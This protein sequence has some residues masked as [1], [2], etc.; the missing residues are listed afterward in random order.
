MPLALK[1]A[2]CLSKPP[3]MSFEEIWPSNK[4]KREEIPVESNDSDAAQ[5]S[6]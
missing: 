5:S 6:S 3:F 2:L 1:E 4:G